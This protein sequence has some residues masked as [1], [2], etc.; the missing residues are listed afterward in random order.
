E[1]EYRAYGF[2]FPAAS[3]RIAELREAATIVKTMWASSPAS[4]QGS[5]YQVADAY[6][7]PRPNPVPKLMIGGGGEKLTLRVAAE[8]ADWWNIGFCPV[9]EY[10]R[11][12]QRLA[13]HCAAVGRDPATITKTYFA[14]VSVAE[15]P[16]KLERRPTMSVL[17][18]TPAEVAGQLARFVELGVEHFQVRFL[19][20]PE[21]RGAELFVEKVLPLL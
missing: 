7:E 15:E 19:D 10:E 6:N 17:A 21:T 12:L 13:E 5:Y 9:E 16:D 8:L 20:F 18:G 4:F 2:P 3:T 14:L 11:K 1:D